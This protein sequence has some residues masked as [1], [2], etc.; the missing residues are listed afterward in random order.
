MKYI[1]S[2]FSEVSKALIMLLD[3]LNLVLSVELVYFLR[4]GDFSAGVLFLPL[5]WFFVLL[6]LISLYIFGTYDLYDDMTP[7]RLLSRVIRAVFLGLLGVVFLNYAFAQHRFGF[8][9]RGVLLGTFGLFSLLTL[10]SRMFSYFGGQKY[11]RELEWLFVV[12]ASYLPVLKSDLERNRF[13]GKITF[14]VEQNVDGSEHD[15]WTNFE[16][17]SNRDWAAIVMAVDNTEMPIEIAEHL[18]VARLSG[19]YIFDVS[20]FYEK[21]WQR[22]PIYFLKNSW[23]ILS[24]GFSLIHQ[25]TGQKLKRLIDLGLSLC[26]LALTWPLMVLTALAVVIESRGGALFKQ[27]RIG[28]SGR[29]FTI[30]KFRSMRSDAEKDGAQWAVTNDARVTRVGKFIRTS[31]LDELPQLFNVIRGDMSFIGPRP[32]RAEFNQNL[33]KQIPFYNVRHLVRPGITGWAQVLFPYGASVEDA[34]EKLQL[35][36]YYIKNYSPL[37]DLM[38][39]LKTV[40]V[41]LLG[42]GR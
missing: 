1:A 7:S 33:E 38:I 37:L 31:R 41:V 17:Y 20:E 25:P 3:L 29:S 39:I 8:L 9:G 23:F 26:L 32:E 6:M 40:S 10:I 12:S 14:L 16:E 34:K 2:G 19:Q 22:V 24:E 15:L 27:A 42:R 11:R 35:E 5:F 13:N 21:Q 18:M 36:L 4:M 30:Y 28:K